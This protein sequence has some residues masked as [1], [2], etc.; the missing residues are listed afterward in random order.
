M[1]ILLVNVTLGRVGS[2]D[3]SL[4]NIALDRVVTDVVLLSS[5]GF[6]FTS[7]TARALSNMLYVRADDNGLGGYT[8]SDSGEKYTDRIFP[9][10]ETNGHQDKE[11]KQAGKN[12][13]PQALLLPPSF[14]RLSN[15]RNESYPS[16]TYA[17]EESSAVRVSK[18]VSCGMQG[19]MLKFFLNYED[20]VE[21]MMADAEASRTAQRVRLTETD[22]VSLRHAVHSFVPNDI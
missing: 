6:S 3:K 10:G 20:T 18:A 19:T 5:V 16:R 8:R 9:N 14:F 2:V 11:G 15:R 7:G 21:K 12:Q 22:I 1:T 4:F 17:T 13:P